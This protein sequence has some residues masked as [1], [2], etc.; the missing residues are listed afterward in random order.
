MSLGAGNGRR[1][2]LVGKMVWGRIWRQALL[3]QFWRMKRKRYV[4]A[5]GEVK[6]KEVGQ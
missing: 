1:E 2:L 3:G 5:P 6:E 4:F